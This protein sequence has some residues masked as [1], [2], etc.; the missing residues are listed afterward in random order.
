M[1]LHTDIPTNGEI[2]R[3]LQARGD[4]LV[5]IYL[6]TNPVTPA[7]EADRIAF[8]NLARQAVEELRGRGLPAREPAEIEEELDDLH[9]DDAFWTELSHSL[10]V[11]A[12]VDGCVASGC[13]TVSPRRSRSPIA[14]TS[15]R[16]CAR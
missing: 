14:S 9:D 13:R 8:K 10:A 1:A 3:L 2:G 16:C 11:F 7:A 12:S 15:S 4:G 6:P 5:S